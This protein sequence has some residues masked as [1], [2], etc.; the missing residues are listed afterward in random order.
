MP[1]AWAQRAYSILNL[2]RPLQEVPDRRDMPPA[3]ASGFHAAGVQLPGQRPQAGV[4][5]ALQV[6]DHRRQAS[7]LPVTASQR[8]APSLLARLSAAAPFVGDRNTPQKHIWR[9]SIVLASARG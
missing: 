1:T 6:G 2:L 4:T 3:A 7:A 9:A 5:L 8:A